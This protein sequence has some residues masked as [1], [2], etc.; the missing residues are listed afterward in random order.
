MKQVFALFRNPAT[1]IDPLLT[2]F[3]EKVDLYVAFSVNKPHK[4]NS[5]GR[6]EHFFLRNAK[7]KT[8]WEGRDYAIIQPEVMRYIQERSYDVIFIATS[9]WSLTTWFALTKARKMG[10]PVITRMTAGDDREGN[11]L[12]K[13]IKKV[14]V[15]LYCKKVDAGVYECEEQ[16]KYFTR[17]GMEEESLFFAPCAVDNE[18]F[19]SLRDKY[20]KV[21]TRKKMGLEDGTIA[22]IFTG[23][24]INRKRPLDIIHAVRNLKTNGYIVE[25]FILGSGELE[26]KLKTT[27]TEIDLQKEVHFCGK[28]DHEIMAEY[29]SACDIYILPSEYDPS[30]KALNEAMNFGL[31]V[32]ISDGIKT[33]KEMC[34]TGENGYVFPVGD[35]DALTKAIEMVI[36]NPDSIN[37]MGRKSKEIVS[38]YNFD[39]VTEA[40]LSAIEYCIRKEKHND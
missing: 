36:A 17:Y 3:G 30:P 14:V 34:I 24:L 15:T 23:Q 9:Y 38:N 2:K 10:I 25:L 40:W 27:V 32:I 35:I 4:E 8:F 19:C 7:K 39:T 6:L 18:Y 5:L 21:L 12:I 16:K 11:L 28:V 13:L 29:L 1:Y 26:D 37:N 33:A 31:P 22:L 20:D